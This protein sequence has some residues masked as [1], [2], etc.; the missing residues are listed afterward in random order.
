[1]ESKELNYVSPMYHCSLMWWVMSS[2]QGRRRLKFRKTGEQSKL[3]FVCG[4]SPEV[5]GKC[6]ATSA[7]SQY[8]RFYQ[9]RDCHTEV[10]ALNFDLSIQQTRAI[11]INHN[12]FMH[13][14]DTK[15]MAAGLTTVISTAGTQGC[16]KTIQIAL[17]L[18]VGLIAK[19]RYHKWR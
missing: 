19:I 8:R 13:R 4:Y 9:W 6:S 10:T 15:T 16:A 11:N 18:K 17:E 7:K 1:M 2:V 14:V 3:S 12:R 5:L